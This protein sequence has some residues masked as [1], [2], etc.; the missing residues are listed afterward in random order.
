VLEAVSI[1]S[2]TPSEAG[3]RSHPERQ[4]RPPIRYGVD[5]YADAVS[6]ELHSANMY[7]TIEP[8]TMQEALQSDN[9]ACWKEAADSEYKF[10]V[11]NKAWELQLA[12]QLLVASG[13]LG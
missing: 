2:V 3:V 1:E 4:I 7:Q 5:E 8:S 11:Y 10:L 9:A 6:Q 12:I 13:S